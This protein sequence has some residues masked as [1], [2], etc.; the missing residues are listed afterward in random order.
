MDHTAHEAALSAGGT[1]VSVLPCGIDYPY[2]MEYRSFRDQI[3]ERGALLSEYPPGTQLQKWTFRVRNRILS[4]LSA[5][6]VVAEASAKSGTM[7]TARYALEQDRDVFAVPAN[8]GPQSDGSNGLI[9]MGAKL[10]TCAEDILE[11]YEGRYE[12]VAVIDRAASHFRQELCQSAPVPLAGAFSADA[13][14]VYRA[15]G[16]VPVTIGELTAATGLS[17]ARLLSAL[18]ELEMEEKIRSYA[19]RRYAITET[20]YDER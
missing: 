14:T 6:I 12:R 7:I 1:T 17:A 3:A 8:V 11:E 18:T 19:G 16:E 13:K 20:A 9:R 4:G 2:L 10:V 15:L 5:G